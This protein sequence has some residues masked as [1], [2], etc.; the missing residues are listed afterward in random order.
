MLCS[1]GPTKSA[2]LHQ[3]EN[4]N[5]H[6]TTEARPHEILASPAE[7]AAARRG[8]KESRCTNPTR[9]VGKLQDLAVCAPWNPV[10]FLSRRRFLGRR[11]AVIFYRHKVPLP[12]IHSE[13]ICDHLPSNRKSRPID[14]P[15]SLLSLVDQGQ[16]MVLSGRTPRQACSGSS[17]RAGGAGCRNTKSRRRPKVEE[18]ACD[19]NL[20]SAIQTI[21]AWALSCRSR[22]FGFLA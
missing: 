14:I 17:H 11:A 1:T 15:F 10:V 2:S 21:R 16:L 19:G 13:Q 3:R 18:V 5:A 20:P 6:R 8:D 7:L 4:G 9:S 22:A 12:S